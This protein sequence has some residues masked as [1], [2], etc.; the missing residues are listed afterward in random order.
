MFSIGEFSK[1]AKVS[2]KTLRYYDEVGLLKPARTDVFSN[3]RYY[4]TAQLTDLQRIIAMK[5]AG[6]TISDI[7]AILNGGDTVVLLKKTKTELAKRHKLLKESI[8]RL[9]LL[10]KNKGEIDMKYHATIKDIPE[11]TVFYKQGMVEKFADLNEFI[12]RAGEEVG[13]ANPNLKC[14]KP[15]YCYVSYLDG[16]YREKDIRVEYAQA[17]ERTGVDT[18][19]IK[20]KTI[21]PTKAVSVYHKGAWG[22]LGETYAYAMNWMRENGMEPTE[23]AREV[24]IDGPWNKKSEDEYLTEIQIPVK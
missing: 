22:K 11:Y 23:L 16:E 20:F 5:Q 7:R 18:D 2:V 17:V 8:A 4:D 13:A 6:L 14:I 3:Y 15:D 1:M 21:E 12:L 24:Y 10:I 9:D 19:T